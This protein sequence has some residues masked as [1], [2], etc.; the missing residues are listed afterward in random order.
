LQKIL[1]KPFTAPI[2]GK[3]GIGKTALGHLLLKEFS[4]HSAGRDAYIM[5]FPN[6]QAD[7]LPE[8]VNIPPET[9]KMSDWPMDST[10]L[11]HGAHHLLHARRSMNTENIELDELVTVSRHKNSNSIF[12]TQQSQRLDR[13]AVTAL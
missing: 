1:I 6:S 5:G 3:R 9:T 10:V 2:I 11:L 8:W 13:N 4:C 7:H 12:E